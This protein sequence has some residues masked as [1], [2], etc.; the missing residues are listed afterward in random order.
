MLDEPM[1]IPFRF[2]F[3]TLRPF[4]QRLQALLDVQLLAAWQTLSA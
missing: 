2:G 1:V 3:H 4:V